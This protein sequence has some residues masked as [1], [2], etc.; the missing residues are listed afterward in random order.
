MILI[1]ATDGLIALFERYNMAIWPVQV[2]AFFLGLLAV[3]LVFTPVG[4]A[5]R[6]IGAILATCWLWVGIVFL[7]IFG[8]EIAPVVA[9][10]EGAVVTAQ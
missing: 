6:A 7:G 5:D 2:I 8:R 10:V 4:W 9:V 3:A 1:A